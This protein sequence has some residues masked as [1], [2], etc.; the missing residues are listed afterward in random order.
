[1]KR[2]LNRV[3]M[4]QAS[5]AILIVTLACGLSGCVFGVT[6][7]DVTHSPLSGTMPKREGTILVKQFVDGRPA[8]HREYIG[9]K[10]NGYG[11]VLGH[12]GTQDGVDLTKLL[13][14]YF[15]EALRHAGYDAVLQPSPS[16][17]NNV[18]FDV[19]LEGEIKE[20]WLDL[21]MATWHNIDVLLTLKDNSDTRVLW[22]R[23]VHGD[24]TNVLWIGVSAE[25]EKVIRQALDNAM[26][27]AVKELAS[28]EFQSAV[29]HGTA[30]PGGSPS[31]LPSAR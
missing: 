5:A 26:D 1:M 27:Q 9:N 13:T 19:V 24:K 2:S 18:V 30:P 21:Y 4:K 16:G 14:G 3:A 12:V 7:L 10:R 8:G 15:V 22:E 17:S 31:A 25:F 6:K 20:F 23:N 28:A 29:Q 11:M